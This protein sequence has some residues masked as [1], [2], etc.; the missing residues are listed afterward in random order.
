MIKTIIN[1]ISLFFC[2]WN[3]FTFSVACARVYRDIP[4]VS[5][6]KRKNF[7]EKRILEYLREFIQKNCKNTQYQ[8]NDIENQDVNSETIWVMWW[9]G[10]EGMPPIVRACWNQLNKVSS[11]HKIILITKENWRNYIQL[12]NYIIE[13][14]NKGKIT[15]THFSDIIRIYLLNYYGGLWIDATVWVEDLPYYCFNNRLFTLHGPG[16]F[17]DFI[18]RGEWVPFFLGTNE[19]NYKLF[20]NI[21]IILLN[22]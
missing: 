21:N 2:Y 7:Y 17:P 16:M 10:V 8:T 20:S 11:S 5:W 3:A 18:S 19:R 13:K 9:Q 4:F 22:L 1:L 6:N 15:L 14:V 12:P